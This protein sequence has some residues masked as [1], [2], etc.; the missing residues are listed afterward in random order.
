MKH[1]DLRPKRPMTAK[2]WLAFDPYFKP[3]EFACPE[4]ERADMDGEF[5]MRLFMLRKRLAFPMTITSGYRNAAHNK[6]VGGGTVSAHLE[7]RAADFRVDAQHMYDVVSAATAMGFAGIGIR[8]K[9]PWHARFIH[10]DDADSLPER[11]PRPW[12]WT[13]DA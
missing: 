13:Y 4:C 12:I 3:D 9:G 11:R 6:A 8:G 5:M 2:D 1:L 10:L 7:G